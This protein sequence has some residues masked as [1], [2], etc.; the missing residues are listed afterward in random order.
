[1]STTDTTTTTRSR[2]PSR[3]RRAAPARQRHRI[4]F[5]RRRGALRAPP[6]VDSSTALHWI[7]QEGDIYKVGRQHYLVAPLPGD[8]LETLIAAAAATEDD[9]ENG[10]LEASIEPSIGHAGQDLEFAPG[11]DDGEV[12]LGWAN[13]G[14]QLHLTTGYDGGRDL[15]SDGLDDRPFGG[16]MSLGWANEGSQALLT[17]RA[18]EDEPSLG[19]GDGPQLSLAKGYNGAGE[20]ESD[21]NCD[22]EPD[23]ESGGDINSQPQDEPDQDIEPDEDGANPPLSDAHIEAQRG[24]IA[25][26]WPVVGDGIVSRRLGERV[27]P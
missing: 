21:E 13:T 6:P 11:E 24:R 4:L 22:D 19:W 5:P 17:G 27:R 12:S 23:H 16:D 3:R 15:E 25:S 7:M 26:R 1:M 8:L 10:D 14:P 20:N 9:E 2:R 18:D